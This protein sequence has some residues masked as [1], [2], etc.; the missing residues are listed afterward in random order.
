MVKKA[1]GGRNQIRKLLI[2]HLLKVLK[3][4]LA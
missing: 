1:M 4:I 3:P 2:A